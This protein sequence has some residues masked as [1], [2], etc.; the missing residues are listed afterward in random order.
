MVASPMDGINGFRALNLGSAR[1]RG[2]VVVM[3]PPAQSKACPF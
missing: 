1:R 2:K 3:V